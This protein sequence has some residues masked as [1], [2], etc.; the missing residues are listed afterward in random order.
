MRAACVALQAW[1]VKLPLAVCLRRSNLVRRGPVARNPLSLARAFARVARD[2]GLRAATR[3]ARWRLLGRVGRALVGGRLAQLDAAVASTHA[4]Q[5]E[6]RGRLAG[7]ECSYANLEDDAHRLI[8]DVAAVR[9]ALSEMRHQAE[10]HMHALGARV[11]ALDGDVGALRAMVDALERRDTVRRDTLL[12]HSRSVR[13]LAEHHTTA[14]LPAPTTGALVSVIMPVWNR[15][16]TVGAAIETVLAQSYQEWELLVIDDGSQDDTRAAVARYSRDPRV[17]YFFQE[18]AGC[19]RARNRGLA[20]SRGEVVAYLD[21]DNTLEPGYLAAVSAA[22]AAHPERDAAYFGQLV[23]DHHDDTV[24]VRA[25]P[26]DRARLAEGNYVD[27]NVFAHRRHLVDRLGGFDE[28]L[29]RLGDWDLVLRY[30]AHAEPLVIRA[31]GGRYQ[32]GHPD[33]ISER[34]S[35]F[36]DYYHVRRKLER[37]VQP[38][39]RV[40]Y[41]LWHYPQLSEAYVRAEIRCMQRWG[42]HIEVWSEEDAPAP[43]PSEVPVHRGPLDAAIER[44]A[45][46]VVHVHWLNMAARYRDA[47]AEA[48]LPLTVR[49]H[50]FEYS[51]SLVAALLEDD[52]VRAVYLFPHHAVAYLATDGAKVRALSACFDPDL[53]HTGSK[54]TSLILR[55]A[56]GLPSKDLPAFIRIAT[57]CPEHHFVLAVCRAARAEA[58][59][60]ELAAYNRSLGSPV[61]LR[62]D[63]QHEEVAALA[64]HAGIYLHT[65]ALL[66][67]YG[68]PTSIAEA[69]ATGAYVLGR[70]CQPAEHYIGDAGRLYESEAEA[71]ALVRETAAWDDARWLRARNTSIDR[72]Y[73]HFASG[74]VLHPMLDDW[75]AVADERGWAAT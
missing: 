74:R 15:A 5:T 23:F 12:R 55:S 61:D 60:E 42:V 41:A 14:T 57:R 29:S 44:V 8:G 50:G 13:W 2:Q 3:E 36:H 39:L 68:M 18:H 62:V 31:V 58:Y 35:Y 27:V 32:L 33:Q 69:M 64:G 72:A 17:R 47:V 71:A 26:F 37:P 63:L 6:L 4:A 66:D 30:T 20:E 51:T 70:R 10:Q 65:H 43:F 45:P 46:H 48:K 38:P 24:F 54:D 22:F 9:D 11:D 34:E 28:R 40:L 25:E 52:V 16:A 75:T 21:S 19:C 67:P 1:A 59:V 53:Y 73:A 49:A 56:V 7:L